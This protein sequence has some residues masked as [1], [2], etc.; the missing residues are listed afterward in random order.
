MES[1]GCHPNTN[2][3]FEQSKET[4]VLTVG[5]LCSKATFLSS[6]PVSTQVITL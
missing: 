1:F 6:T 4:D 5:L 3:A 2:L